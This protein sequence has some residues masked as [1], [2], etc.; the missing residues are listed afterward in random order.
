LPLINFQ[1]DAKKEL[2]LIKDIALR[3]KIP[4]ECLIRDKQI[5]LHG[6]TENPVLAE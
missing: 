5:W 4:V 6:F 2:Y 3:R 1:K